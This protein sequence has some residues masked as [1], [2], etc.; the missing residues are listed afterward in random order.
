M[1]ARKHTMM[2][3]RWRP[4]L[5]QDRLPTIWPKYKWVSTGLRLL[6]KE[7]S[8]FWRTNWNCVTLFYGRNLYM[9][10]A[11][12]YSDQLNKYCLNQPCCAPVN[13][14]L[15]LYDLIVC[16]QIS[17]PATYCD[18]HFIQFIH[19]NYKSALLCNCFLQIGSEY[20]KMYCGGKQ[21]FY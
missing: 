6:P 20:L 9:V 14:T 21:N 15:F 2:L 13:T 8:T 16:W 4:L 12:V 3:F 7:E 17:I 5:K 19:Y 11:N 18:S 1:S 10:H